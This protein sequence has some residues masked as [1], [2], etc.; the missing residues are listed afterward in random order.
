MIAGVAKTPCP[1]HCLAQFTDLYL[2]IASFIL[3]HSA[4]N[5]ILL[6]M[7]LQKTQNKDTDILCVEVS[8]LQNLSLGFLSVPQR[9]YSN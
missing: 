6:N 1:S 2:R 3:A 5:M 9:V 7:Q 4:F 8:A